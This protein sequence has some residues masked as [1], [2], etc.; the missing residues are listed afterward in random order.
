MGEEINKVEE[1]DELVS[2]EP[3]EDNKS[4]YPSF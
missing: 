4:D 1:D 3:S 2:E